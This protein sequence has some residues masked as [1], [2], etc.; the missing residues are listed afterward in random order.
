MI[1]KKGVGVAWKYVDLVDFT[2]TY[3]QTGVSVRVDHG[4][5]SRAWLVPGRL[6]YFAVAGAAP[7]FK[8]RGSERILDLDRLERDFDKF[9]ES[10]G[11]KLR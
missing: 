3:V 8:W 9:H 5:M 2:D 6:Y 1:I 7:M 4:R 11:K 10:I